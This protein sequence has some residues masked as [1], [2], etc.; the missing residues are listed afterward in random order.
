MTLSEVK[1]LNVRLEQLEAMCSGLGP[2]LSPEQVQALIG[3][4]ERARQEMQAHAQTLS[5]SEREVFDRLKIN[6]IAFVN[7]EERY[8]A[9]VE[10]RDAAVRG[11]LTVE[12][13]QNFEDRLLALRRNHS[14]CPDERPRPDIT[15]TDRMEMEYV[16]ARYPEFVQELLQNPKALENFFKWS[17]RSGCSVDVFVQFPKMAAELM[18]CHAD[19][20][21]GGVFGHNRE[22]PGIRVV[23]GQVRMKVRGGIAGTGCLGG[24]SYVPIQDPDLRIALENLVD[25]TAPPYIVT[26][27]EI[28]RQLKAKTTRYE[29]VEVLEGGL[30]SWNTIE[31]GSYNPATKRVLRIDP[32]H[33]M[34]APSVAHVTLQDI[35]ACFPGQTVEADGVKFCMCISR[36]F[37]DTDNGPRVD[38]T[39]AFLTVFIPEEG[40]RYRELCLGLQSDFLPK[41][42]YH[43]LWM[44]ATTEPAKVHMIDESRYLIGDMVEGGFRAHRGLIYNLNEVESELL[45]AFIAREM[46]HGFDGKKTFSPKGNN[47][48]N[49]VQKA[50][51]ELF[52]GP[53]LFNRLREAAQCHTNPN[54]SAY[55]RAVERATKASNDE[56]LNTAVEMVI[57]NLDRNLLVSVIEGCHDLLRRTL[58]KEHRDELPP[59]NVDVIQQADFVQLRLQAQQ[60][61]IETLKS[62][63]F[64]R[65]RVIHT[66]LSVAVFNDINQ[67]FKGW[68]DR[69]GWREAVV[70]VIY[71]VIDFIFFGAWRFSVFSTDKGQ[72]FK[73]LWTSK[74]YQAGTLPLPAAFR[75]WE[76]QA[77]QKRVAIGDQI[78]DR[79]NRLQ[80]ARRSNSVVSRRISGEHSRRRSVGESTSV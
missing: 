6:L 54:F 22:D 57:Q 7:R 39:H 9:D 20:R 80:Q 65:I 41:N 55:L 10:G 38:N 5:E 76:R 23:R 45:R 15:A 36:Q 59:L 32:Q 27:G 78:A 25:H 58:Y 68:S 2:Q 49:W 13:R 29:N 43:K 47:C 75:L 63:Q 67:K 69:G 56:A 52:V 60:L 79:I 40:E 77:P 17:C 8:R 30:S 62:T 14:L 73:S 35:R 66:D 64:F 31:C 1:T 44:I 19:K 3:Q 53:L 37:E 21:F 71:Q 16:C 18:R 24:S 50:F 74:Y 42:F 11:V 61:L 33:W 72:R 70:K 48:A 12:E 26:V 28:F 46:Q 4:V 34:A 51:W